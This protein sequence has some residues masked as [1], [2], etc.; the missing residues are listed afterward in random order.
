MG[1]IHKNIHLLSDFEEKENHKR[2]M[3]FQLLL[4]HTLNHIT[5]QQASLISQCETVSS[6]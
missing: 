3:F 2:T 4:V 5:V 1:A 6:T